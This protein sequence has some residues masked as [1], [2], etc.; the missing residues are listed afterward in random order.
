MHAPAFYENPAE[1][2]AI[3][4]GVFCGGKGDAIPFLGFFNAPLFKAGLF[5]K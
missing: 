1:Y 4:G 5:T 3:Y 2:P